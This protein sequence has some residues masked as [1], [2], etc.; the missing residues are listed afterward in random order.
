M[1]DYTQIT[2]AR[3]KDGSWNVSIGLWVADDIHRRPRLRHRPWE[4]TIT[5]PGNVVQDQIFDAVKA[6]L[7]SLAGPAA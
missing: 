7:R 5:V 4:H 6:A 2:L 3:H 1:L